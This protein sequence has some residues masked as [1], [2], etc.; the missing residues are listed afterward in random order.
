MN[1]GDNSSGKF[2]NLKEVYE[3]RGTGSGRRVLGKRT[4]EVVHLGGLYWGGA[5]KILAVVMSS[6][7]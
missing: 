7:Y 4:Q 3:K 6:Y 1:F 2:S 5:L